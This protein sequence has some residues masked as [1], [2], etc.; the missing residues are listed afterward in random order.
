MDTVELQA[1]L[2]VVKDARDAVN[3]QGKFTEEIRNETKQ[4][5]ITKVFHPLDLVAAK[6]QLELDK[7]NRKRKTTKAAIPQRLP[8]KD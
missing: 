5:R 1:I 7:R 2:N 8:Y 3:W 4:F 6:L